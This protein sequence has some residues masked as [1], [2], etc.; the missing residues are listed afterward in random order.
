MD[1]H[2]TN[3][4]RRPQLQLSPAC[5]AAHPTVLTTDAANMTAQSLVAARLDYGNG[6]L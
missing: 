6:L 3:V 4:T 1:Q 5:V 2:V